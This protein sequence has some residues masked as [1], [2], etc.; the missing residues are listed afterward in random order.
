[1]A[2]FGTPNVVH[3]GAALLVAVILCAPWPALWNAGVL[4]GLAG[5]GGVIY[6]LFVLWQARHRVQGYQLVR[7]DPAP[8]CGSGSSKT[9]KTSGPP[10]V[11][12]PIAFI[13]VSSL[14]LS[15]PVTQEP[16]REY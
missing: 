4:L 15:L 7:S 13:V 14:P 11:V 2:V 12:T 10:N 16:R 3:F 6:I 5:L 9:C 1:M 8:A